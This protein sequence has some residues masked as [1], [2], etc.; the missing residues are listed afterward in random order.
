[1][2]TVIE[3]ENR[4][5]EK[6]CRSAVQDLR[7]RFEFQCDVGDS[8]SSALRLMHGMTLCERRCCSPFPYFSL[9]K[10]ASISAILPA[11]TFSK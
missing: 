4:H 10:S 6:R 5:P 7:Q 1:M 8:V 9:A 11:T 3:T 2:T